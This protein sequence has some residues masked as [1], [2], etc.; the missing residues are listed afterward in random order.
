[1]GFSLDAM[2]RKIASAAP[3][4]SSLLDGICN[5]RK[6]D[7]CDMDVD[8]DAEDT[9]SDSESETNARRKVSPEQLL[10]IVS[11][12]ARCILIAHAAIEEGY[13]HEHRLEHAQSEVQCISGCD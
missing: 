5:R 12:F 9:E 7:D 3:G 8:E 2:G 6:M 13:H 1:M 4:L 10:K 11:L